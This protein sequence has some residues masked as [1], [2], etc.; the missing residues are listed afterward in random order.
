[1]SKIYPCSIRFNNEDL[2]NS[3]TK[4]TV[5][6]LFRSFTLSFAGFTFIYNKEN[7]T[8]RKK[9]M[10]NARHA[11]YDGKGVGQFTVVCSVTWP[12]NGREGWR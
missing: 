10:E 11:R 1:M 7:Q 4:L 3:T 2:R 6:F 12:L 5:R 9:Y 8:G